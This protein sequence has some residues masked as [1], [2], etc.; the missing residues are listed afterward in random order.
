[1][2]LGLPLST[3]YAFLLVLARVSGFVAFLPL[4]VF[5]ATA[6]GIRVIFALVVTFAL[7]PAWP[8]IANA[9]VPVGQLVAWAA[10]EAGF[11]LAAGIATAFLT[12]TFQLAMQ[13]LGLQAG[14]GYATTIDPTSQADSSVLQVMSMLVTGLLFFSTGLDRAL[15]R[16]LAK[17]FETFPAGSWTPVARNLD[18]IVH[19][20]SGMFSLGLRIAMPVVAF[21]LLIDVAL[22]LVGRMQQQLQL[23]SMA[24]PAKMLAALLGLA[25]LSPVMAKMFDSAAARTMEALARLLVR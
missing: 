21:L 25:T 13:I 5:R 22:A 15:L 4:P 18:G 2:T 12:E 10:A 8:N 24:F 20:G 1:M 6:D 9:S 19:L 3:M 17:S 11:G 16:V 14:Y 23:L 7:F